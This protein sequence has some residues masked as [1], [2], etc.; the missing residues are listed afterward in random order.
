MN[1]HLRYSYPRKTKSKKIFQRC[2]KKE[3]NVTFLTVGEHVYLRFREED[4]G[5]NSKVN[6]FVTSEKD[7]F[8]GQSKK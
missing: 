6:F 2:R 4:G 7:K 5:G 8:F 1:C 3:K